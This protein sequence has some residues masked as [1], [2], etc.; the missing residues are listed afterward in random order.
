[1]TDRSG[2]S[3]SAKTPLRKPKNLVLCFDGTDQNFGPDPFTNVLKIFRML[4]SND[5]SIQMCYYQPGIG[6]SMSVRGG[7]KSSTRCALENTF[8]SMFAFSLDHHII[9]AYL[10]LVQYYELDDKIIMFGFSRGAFIARVL[11]GMLERVGILK[12]GLENIVPMAWKIYAAWEY[13]CQPSQPDYTT[14]LIDE[15]RNTFAR[16]IPIRVHFEGLFDSVNS[17]GIIRDRLFPY[18]SRSGIVDHVRHACSVDERR[19]KFKQQSFSPNPYTQKLFSFVYRNYMIEPQHYSPLQYGYTDSERFSNP[20]I[21]STLVRTSSIP[22][23]T[24]RSPDAG[25]FADGMKPDS[26][27]AA[28]L[29]RNVADYLEGVGQETQG[30]WFRRRLSSLSKQR[31]EGVFQHYSPGNES[32]DRSTFVSSDLV[33]KWFPG[34]HS[35]VGGGW[36]P[37]IETEQF[38]SNLSLRWMLSEA[39]KHGVHFKKGIIHQFANTYDSSSSVLSASHDMLSLKKGQFTMQSPFTNSSNPSKVDLDKFHGLLKVPR[40]VSSMLRVFKKKSGSTLQSASS[41]GHSPRAFPPR[42]IIRPAK[43]DGHGTKSIFQVIAWWIVEMMFIGIRIEDKNCQWKNVYVPNLGRHRNIPAYGE[44]HWSVYWRCKYVGDYRPKNL[45]PY[46]EKLIEHYI[47]VSLNNGK[48]HRRKKMASSIPSKQVSY[49]TQESSP[50]L[51][52]AGN[53]TCARSSLEVDI[54]AQADEDRI[55][56]WIAEDWRNVPDELHELLQRNP[57][58]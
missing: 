54:L 42:C 25:L 4:E 24:D 2:I 19:G 57:D 46:A 3:D 31:V 35:D 39:I 50:L 21:N 33:E 49:P 1:M 48:E 13:A 55:R 44:L 36:A 9:S 11:T 10:F 27:S 43:N 58:L 23:L 34:D 8:D 32:S 18:T 7:D 53:F 14:T 30:S 5:D 17:C 38:L 45:P 15:F 40:K 16:N 56:K 47:G 52:P 26:D 22:Q 12:R 41:L 51:S 37:D 6:T 20:F 29:L 28:V